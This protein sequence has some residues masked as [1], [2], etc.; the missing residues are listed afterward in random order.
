MQLVLS[1][2]RI[3]AHGEGFRAMGGVVI[4][5]ETGAKYDNA[6]IAECEGGCPSDINKVGYEYHAGRF[7]P[8]APFGMG[9]GNVA[10]YCDDCKT[11]R[12]SGKSVDDF[13]GMSSYLAFVA[14]QDSDT[15][16]A[17]FGKNNEDMVRGVGA[18]FAMYGWFKGLD[19]TA[20]PFTHLRKMPTLNDMNL[21][22]YN[23][24]ISDDNFYLYNLAIASPY[25]KNKVFDVFSDSQTLTNSS[26]AIGDTSL[27]STT[28]ITITE[29]HLL[30]KFILSWSFN[31]A[32]KAGG[33]SKLYINDILLER[34]NSSGESDSFFGLK[35]WNDYNISVPGTYNVR[36]VLEA[37][38]APS[39]T[40]SSFTIYCAKEY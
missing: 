19:K 8:C 18:G 37:I 27:E 35:D 11:P 9:T 22:I 29:G 2:N 3:I 31:N 1:N 10:V 12:D 15:I 32:N 30:S 13:Y 20:Y 6:T 34:T 23:E 24:I 26:S 25:A 40:K 5:A 14:S 36:L 21:D 39:T 28:Q 4:N 17:A 16:D 38:V 7:V 33:G